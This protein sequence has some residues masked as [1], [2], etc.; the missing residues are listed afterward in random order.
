MRV[1]LLLTVALGLAAF[2]AKA[3]AQSPDAS[4]GAAISSARE[5]TFDDEA[6][7]AEA[8]RQPAMINGCTIL[9]FYRLTPKLTPDG[10]RNLKDAKRFP[11]I[12]F[13]R[14]VENGARSPGWSEKIGWADARTCPALAEAVKRMDALSPKFS[15]DAPAR[16]VG[17][18]VMDGVGY[19]LW[20]SGLA[21]PF[22]KLDYRY[23]LDITSNVGT[24]LAEWTERT[25]EAIRGCLKPD[26]PEPP[27]WR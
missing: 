7:F 14:M 19:H 26:T 17:G 18:H 12:F 15:G 27:T 23:S 21:A 16:G 10:S 25:V 20:A 22:D 5:R 11:P 9:T 3:E 13:A 8:T 1:G 24:P 4:C 2:G 6:P